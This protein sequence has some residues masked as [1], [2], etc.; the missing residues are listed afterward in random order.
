MDRSPTKANK[1]KSIGSIQLT[2]SEIAINMDSSSRKQVR[3]KREDLQKQL[4]DELKEIVK[5]D[6]AKEENVTKLHQ[7]LKDNRWMDLEKLVKETRTFDSPND[8]TAPDIMIVS[9]NQVKAV[10]HLFDH[11]TYTE[12]KLIYIKLIIEHFKIENQLF[13]KRRYAPIHYAVETLD[14]NFLLWLLKRDGHDPIDVNL[15]NKNKKT[16]L[17]MLCEEY[18]KCKSA[19]ANVPEQERRKEKCEKILKL[20]EQLLHVGADFNIYSNSN[21]LPF[22]LL[23]KYYNDDAAIKRLVD[24]HHSQSISAIAYRVGQ[25]NDSQERLIKFYRKDQGNRQ[26]HVTAELLELFL[27]F[28][29]L[30]SFNEHWESFSVSEGEVKKVI[31]LV[32]QVAVELKLNDIVHQIVKSAQSLIFENSVEKP[33]LKKHR[34]EL[35]DLLLSA[36]L[37]GNLDIIKLLIPLMKD[38]EELVNYDPLLAQ[39]LEKSH[40]N[41]QKQNEHQALLKCAMYLIDSNFV[42]LHK[43]TKTKNTPLHLAVKFGYESF[44]VKLLERGCGSLGVCNQANLTPLECGTY[45]FWKACFDKFIKA[46]GSKQDWKS[47]DFDTTCFTP[48]SAESNATV[49]H[50]SWN[51]WKLIRKATDV[52]VRAQERVVV[53]EMTPLRRMAE[54]KELKRLL[55]HPVVYS[56]VMVKWVRLSLIHLLNLLLAMVTIGSFGMYSLSTC[57]VVNLQSNIFVLVLIVLVC[58]LT[59]LR[60]GMQLYL[61]P[62]SYATLENL[63]DIV[64]IVVIIINVASLSCEPILSSFVLLIFSLQMVFMLSALPF[65]RLSTIMYMFKTVAINFI[66]SL[67]LFLPLIG[68]FVFAF[69]LT[70]NGEKVYVPITES[71]QTYEANETATDGDF[72]KFGTIMNSVVKTVVMTTGEFDAA[73]LDLSGGKVFLFCV[74]LF[75]APLVILNLMNGLAVSDISTIQEKSELISIMRVQ[76]LL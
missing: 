14:V 76:I 33:E 4:Q 65:K 16:A 51:R 36:A 62:R 31:E 15:R 39:T 22:D 40:A 28:G 21:Q 18:D 24:H 55:T 73:S 70:Y 50:R 42:S 29:D 35:K 72:H 60:E 47:I 52:G 5:Q 19:S 45:N 11:S 7:F 12:E 71:N 41:R 32:L 37:A 58:L 59:L 53:T 46:D 26:V 75:T 8:F 49:T 63:V 17:Y 13:G 6:P 30:D 67:L 27:R 48:P 1:A 9:Y 43:T 3:K 57:K 44:V 2:P 74:F 23:L 25:E 69:Y 20:I 61:L 56:F 54:S 68:T 66:Q 64:S 34:L 10:E 38:D